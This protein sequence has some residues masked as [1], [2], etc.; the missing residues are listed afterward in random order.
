MPIEKLNLI[1]VE[2][3]TL[4][5][6]ISLIKKINELID[7]FNDIASEQATHCEALDNH[8]ERLRKLENATQQKEEETELLKCPFCSNAGGLFHNIYGHY[9]GCPNND[10]EFDCSTDFYETKQEAINAWNKRIK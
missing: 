8:V 3:E 7:Y 6:A 10:C 4:K 2:K 9:I 5:H 1:E